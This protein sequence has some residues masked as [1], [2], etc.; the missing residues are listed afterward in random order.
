M[1]KKKSGR[2][3]SVDNRKHCV[4][5]RFSPAELLE[6]ERLANLTGKSKAE[7]LREGFLLRKDLFERYCDS[8][9]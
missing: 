3:K 1:D 2:P 8:A 7:L 4:K 9:G 6:V 5:V